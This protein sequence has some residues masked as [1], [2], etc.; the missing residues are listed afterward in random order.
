MGHTFLQ[1]LMLM[2]VAGFAA[3]S[4]LYIYRHVV[5]QALWESSDAGWKESL[6]PK[7]TQKR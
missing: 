5:H 6:R 4:M 2:I 1:K 3:A 7:A